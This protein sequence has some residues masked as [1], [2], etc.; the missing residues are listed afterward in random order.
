MPTI[1]DTIQYKASPASKLRVKN[2]NISGIRYNI[3]LVVDCCCGDVPA[4][5]VI[6][7]ITNIDAPTRIGSNNGIG[8]SLENLARSIHRKTPSRGTTSCTIGSQ[9]YSFSASSASLSG[10]D[11]SV[12]LKDQK[13]PKNIG[14]CITS[15]PRQP[16]GLTPCSLYNF[17]VSR[18][19]RARSFVY[20]ACSVWTNG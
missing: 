9:E 20:L 19:M 15:G 18:C 16:R 12:F 5:G 11:G 2:P 7:C 13:R 8:F 10:V 3:I 6:F 1:F 17:M 4:T 14:I